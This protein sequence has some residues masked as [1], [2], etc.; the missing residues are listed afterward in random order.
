MNTRVSSKGQVVIPK[1]YRQKLGLET[2]TEL[3]VEERE[4][5]LLLRPK[6]AVVQK[7]P[8]SAIVGSLRQPGIKSA[9][10]DEMDAAVAAAFKDWEV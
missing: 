2:G 6:P 3:W 7:R 1:A 5:Q 9:S 8:L 4:G 10:T